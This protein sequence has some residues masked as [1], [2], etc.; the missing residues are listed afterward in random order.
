MVKQ[1]HAQKRAIHLFFNEF[2]KK[3]VNEVIKEVEEFR[4]KSKRD[5]GFLE[6]LILKFYEYCYYE[7]GL[8]PDSAKTYAIEVRGYFSKIGFAVRRL[9]YPKLERRRISAKYEIDSE[10]V[11]KLINVLGDIRDKLIVLMKFQGGFDNSTLVN[12]RL[13]NLV[14]LRDFYKLQNGNVIE[15]IEQLETPLVIWGER[16]KTGNRFKTAVGEDCKM[17]LL[18]YLRERQRR[19]E[20]LTW[21]SYVLTSWK[22]LGAKLS[23]V[24]INTNI[25][26]KETYINAGLITEEE[27]ENY[28]FNPLRPHVFR[29]YFKSILKAKGVNDDIVDYMAGH[30]TKHNGAYDLYS[31]DEI[32]QAWLKAEDEF[33]VLGEAKVKKIAE[34]EAE[35]KYKSE[36]EA[37][38]REMEELKQIL[39]RGYE[40]KREIEG[41]LNKV[42]K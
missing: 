21:D 23:L 36:L 1:R 17:M 2:L 25:L 40:I 35:K 7:L 22:P 10:V 34:K 32:R 4:E 6:D 9:N 39:L 31:D 5:Y 14:P 37:L 30:R 11:Y 26:N 29:A 28:T 33:T 18:N 27:L 13:R 3:P 42:K 15:V 8:E 19:Y 24:T 20:K 38:K 12:I 41:K 16:H